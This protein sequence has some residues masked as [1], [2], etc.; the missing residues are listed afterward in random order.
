VS[1]E[2][3]DH[4]DAQMK[5]IASMRAA[6]T[7]QRVLE[8]QNSFMVTDE[9]GGMV[10]GRSWFVVPGWRRHPVRRARIALARRRYRAARLRGA[11]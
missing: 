1:I 4:I 2:V 11:R 6:E 10:I 8:G 5:G 9:L 7:E 3:M